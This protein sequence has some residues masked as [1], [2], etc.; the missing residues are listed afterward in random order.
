MSAPT[1]GDP[2]AEAVARLFEEHGDLVYQLGL[3]TCDN[4]D[5]AEDLV[6]ETFLRALKSWGSF[7]GRARPS[8]W[9]YTIATRACS[10]MQRRRAG[11]PRRLEPL[12]RLLPSG[13]ER[14]VQIPSGA[15]PERDAVVSLATDAAR[16]AVAELPVEFRLPFILKEVFDFSVDEVS[17]ILDVKPATVKTRLHRARLR[18]RRSLAELLPTFHETGAED[19]HTDE[20]L[21]L[22]KAKQESLDRGTPF[23]VPPDEL[24]QRC[25]SVFAT[26][27]L[28]REACRRLDTGEMPADLRAFIRRSLGGASASA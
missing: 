4:P 28:G 25:R 2:A 24:C 19:A 1:A 7:E 11:E 8:T 26:L 16:R 22:L 15:D 14:P 27:D 5:A 3:R 13:D 12:E 9:L 6:Q 18:L 10:R 17:E 21:A 23:P 20:C